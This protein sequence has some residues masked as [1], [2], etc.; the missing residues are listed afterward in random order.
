MWRGWPLHHRALIGIKSYNFCPEPDAMCHHGGGVPG[1]HWHC[2]EILNKALLWVTRLYCELYPLIVKLG[3]DR[4]QVCI[5]WAFTFLC[6]DWKTDQTP[7]NAYFVTQVQL[8]VCWT[9]SLAR[10]SSLSIV[11][12]WCHNL[13]YSQCVQWT[14]TMLLW[15]PLKVSQ[16][17]I[18]LK[19]R[20]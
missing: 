12:S 5:W 8:E 7:F 19:R 10:P 17:P 14:K 20:N 4:Q 6:C 16:F 2:S 9:L 1:S 18:S 11:I 3:T 13:V 15:P